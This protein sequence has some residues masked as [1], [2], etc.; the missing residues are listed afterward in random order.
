[1]RPRLGL[2]ITLIALALGAVPEYGVSNPSQVDLDRTVAELNQ[3]HQWLGDAAVRLEVLQTK[4]HAA[5]ESLSLLH[6]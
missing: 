1:M 4:L 6:I 3:L 5:D 2:S